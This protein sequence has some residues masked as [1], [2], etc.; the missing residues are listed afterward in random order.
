MN[1]NPIKNARTQNRT[2]LAFL[3]FYSTGVL[4]CIAVV[5]NAYEQ[6]VVYIRGNAI[7]ILLAT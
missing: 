7:R 1:S 2:V 5:V 4:L 3:V 6:E